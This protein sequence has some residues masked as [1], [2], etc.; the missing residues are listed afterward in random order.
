MCQPVTLCI[1]S[2]QESID[3]LTGQGRIVY[4]GFQISLYAAYRSFQFVGDILCQLFF[5]SACSFSWVMS[6]MEISKLSSWK[7]MHSTAKIRPFLSMFND[8]RFSSLP[9][10]RSLFF[11]MKRVMGCNSG[12]EKIS[13]VELRFLSEIRLAYCVNRLFTRISSL[14][15]LNTPKPSCEI[16]RWVIS[17]SRSIYKSSFAWC[18]RL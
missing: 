13:S 15:W 12:M 3:F 6:L 1:A 7:I 18:R 4:Y 17:F 10:L 16:W 5:R 14:R 9:I 8:I 11:V 2:L